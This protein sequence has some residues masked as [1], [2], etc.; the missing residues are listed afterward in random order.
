MKKISISQDWRFLAQE[1]KGEEQRV[2]LPHTWYRDDDQYRGQAV[3]RKHIGLQDLCPEIQWEDTCLFLEIEAADHT[4]KAVVNGTEI[5]VHK[6][7]YSR[8]HFEIPEDCIRQGSLDLQLYVDNSSGDE[9]SPL[10]G[11]FT[12]FGGL[13]RGV[14]LILSKKTHFDYLY[15]GTDGVI[16]R[17]MTGCEGQGIVSIEPHVV[18]A[19]PQ[20]TVTVRY[21]ILDDDGTAAAESVGTPDTE[22]QIC[23][24]QVRLWN[25]KKDP[26]L[27]TLRA[28]LAENGVCVDSV[29]MKIGFREMRMD[30]QEGFFL[31]GKHLFLRG[32][33]KHQDFAGCFSAV[34][35]REIDRDFEL[36]REIGANAVRLSH[37]QHPQYTYDICDREGYVVWAEI[38]ML[39]MTEKKETMENALQQLTELILQN[40]HHPS[41]CFWG[42]QNEIGMFRDAPYIHRNVSELYEL[43][44]K[45][46]PERIV[47]C[48]NL[49]PMKSKSMLNR[50]TDMVGYNI[51]FGWYYGKMQDY[52]T[53]LDRLH[54]ELPDVP[55]GISEYGV[56]A[57]TWLHSDAPAVKDYSEEFQSLFHQT[58]YPIFEQRSYL[59]GSFVWNMFDFSSS[60]RN[61][62]GQK[63]RN[64]KGLV[65]YDRE[66]RKDAFYYYKAKWSETPFLHICEKRFEK[67]ASDRM[68]L[69]VYTNLK[70]AVLHIPGHEPVCGVND[71]N[72]TVLFEDLPLVKGENTFTVT[73][74]TE[75]GAL[76]ED[77]A[78]FERT[79]KPE[80]S[81]AL[82]DSH[83]GETVQN[84]FLKEEGVDLDQYFSV[85]DRAEDL[86]E[87]EECHRILQ[88]YLPDVTRLLE[89]EIIPLGLS[90]NSILNY[91]KKEGQSIDVQALND[92]LIRVAK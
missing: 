54:E 82:P 69:R 57:Q 16:V 17:T 78:V 34:T 21:M 38:P 88:K 39:K 60:R 18:C 66:T 15:F 71:G 83:A 36:I 68:S 33:A 62:G 74:H 79:E 46:D 25:G 31:N 13:Y 65:T 50:L 76:L 45:L 5:G 35:G 41:I 85:Q 59:W 75:N 90:L 67:R 14:N 1:N 63:Y 40:I 27:Y 32:V 19:D 26:A 28:E 24:P 92:E 7:G 37:Y 84:W 2:D 72:G 86:L 30:S 43:A 73:G 89:R 77:Q 47:T 9:V 22:E 81:Y 12:V 6:G 70:E 91:N 10:A 20:S 53:F 44:K 49:Y 3:Y 80:P 58:V 64:A 61:E 56:D 4:V 52:G 11:D 51:Y 87:N 23:L 42:I 8:I 55:L 29:E 48:A